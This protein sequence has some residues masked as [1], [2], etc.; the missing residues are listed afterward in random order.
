MNSAILGEPNTHLCE[1]VERLKPFIDD[2][3]V[4]LEGDEIVIDD[5]A[6]ALAR[7][8]AACLD[9]HVEEDKAFA[10]PTV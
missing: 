1:A 3:I 10:S 8:V 2:G 4:R 9:P 5:D 6:K 7:R